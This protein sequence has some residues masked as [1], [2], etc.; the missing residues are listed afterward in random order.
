MDE[1]FAID[2]ISG[3]RRGIVADGL[4]TACALS[5][6]VYGAATR[7]R[8]WAYDHGWKKIYSVDLPVISLGNI[9]AGGT[10]KTPIAAFLAQRLQAQGLRPGII[11]RGYRRLND[12]A[13]D[14]RLVLEQLLPGVPQVMNRD[15]VAG[16]R[17]AIQE[18]GCDIILLD[19]GFQ[20]RRL[21]RDVNLVL[22]DA[23]RPWGFGRL[24]PRGLLREPL[25]S[26]SRADVVLITRCDQVSS[27]ELARLRQE[28]FRWRGTSDCVEVQFVPWRLR[29]ARGEFRP[30]SSLDGETC[31]PFCG[32]GNPAGFQRT[33]LGL[34][35]IAAPVV[36]PDHYHYGSADFE[37][38]SR[39]AAAAHA[40]MLLTTQ[41]DLVK[42]PHTELSARPVWAVEIATEIVAGGELLDLA[43][44]TM[45]TLS[46]KRHCRWI[47]GD[48]SA[49][50]V[51]FSGELQTEPNQCD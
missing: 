17:T 28:L 47:A 4:R 48:P 46:R 45:A 35:V 7:A 11:S 39:Q 3:R 15:R 21:K 8:N 6:C 31:L 1:Q 50:R 36:F 18:Q 10:G 27:A 49:A 5:S 41:K 9:T 16:A 42:I 26:L 44:S 12:Q 13:N 43:L 34:N 22:I 29:N 33:L 20:H 19:D 14:E 40:S 32:I 25:S 23:T 38:L 24:L 51:V 30:L 37:R 2:V